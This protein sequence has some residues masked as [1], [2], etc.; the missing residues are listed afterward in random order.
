MPPARSDPGR[1]R[2]RRG[3]RGH[4]VKTSTLVI[5]AVVVAAGL[6]FGLGAAGI[7]SRVSCSSNPVLINVAVSSDIAPA[8]SPLARLFNR[9]MHQADGRC[10]LV[11]VDP[12][13]P[14]AQ[15][16]LIDGQHPAG[17]QSPVQAWIPDSSL[18]VDE[19]RQ[20]P[21]GAQIIQ[22]TGF[23]VA[24]SPLM[25]V[26][27]PAAAARTPAFRKA[28]WRFLLPPSAGGP[29]LRLR[30]GLRVELP[31]PTQSAA[32]LATLIE[33][34][35]L[36]GPGPT[37]GVDYARFVYSTSVTSYFD[38]A[39]ALASFVH[40]AGPPLDG[41]PV[42]VTSEQAVLSYDQANPR[43]PLAAVYPTGSRPDLGSP[44]L[45][46]PYVL[47]ASG[48]VQLAAATEFGQLLRGRYAATVIRFAGFRSASGVPDAFPPS[49]GLSGQLLQVALPASSSEAPTALAAWSRLALGSRN[50]ALVDVSSA[51]SKPASRSG[52]T[53]EQE[54]SRTALLGLALFPDTT[55]IGIWEFAD[56]L[57][58]AL[59]YRPLVSIRPLPA[60]AGAGSGSGAGAGKLSTRQELRLVLTHLAPTGGPQVALY[61]SILAAYRRVLATFAPAFVNSVLVLTSGVEN[62]PG[63]VTARELIKK[64]TAL[65]NPG[66][67]VSVIIIVF[68]RAGD[69]DALLQIAAATGGQAYQ[70]TSPAEIG[71]VFF[72]AVAHRLCDPGCV[73]P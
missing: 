43:Q 50:L 12:G 53:F 19:A 67:P 16:A 73:K 35:R 21:I 6:M 66:K 2:G 13:S 70:V 9:Q 24:R 51:M 54:L 60:S 52:A 1:R 27:P 49:T 4:P 26:M 23:S 14:A 48:R 47:T 41:N 62:A 31:D 58:G 20:F 8:I 68:G 61:G 69:F 5:A 33:I 17:H 65:A 30:S 15:A 18:W 46:Y 63:D 22:P 71:K 39:S 11:Q 45:D 10:V 44:E 7:A 29:R 28:G 38:D 32:G 37:A 42:T 3:R 56:H 55:Q 64:L 57:D 40:L 36:L 34:S 72:Q 59:P 25:I